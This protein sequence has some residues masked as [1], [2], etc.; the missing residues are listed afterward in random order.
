MCCTMVVAMPAYAI[1]VTSLQCVTQLLP[2]AHMITSS[3]PNSPT[4]YS[5]IVVSSHTTAHSMETKPTVIR[6]VAHSYPGYYVISAT[7]SVID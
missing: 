4:P 2:C 3:T 7:L 5:N 6:N 1:S